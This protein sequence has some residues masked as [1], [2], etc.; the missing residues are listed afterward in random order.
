MAAYLTQVSVLLA[1]D[2]LLELRTRDAFGATLLFALLVLVT[3]NF[4]LD[5]RP[6]VMAGVGPGVLWVA[7]LFAGTIGLGRSF[8]VE[9]DQG[10]LE[11]LL[12]A[13]IERSAL[14]VAKLLGS[15]AVMAVTEAVLVP[16]FAALFDVPFDFRA[17][18]PILF[19]GTVGL[20]TVG[21]LLAA[22]AAHTRAREVLLPVLLFP[23]I[24]PLLIGVVEATGV[25][26]AS[27]T[28]Q[29]RPWIGLLLAFDA[30]Y[31][32]VGNLVFEYVLEE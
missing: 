6:E 11:T 12:A 16:I 23:I 14:F 8:A 24:V 32:A 28:G 13:P 20:A 17:L 7:V 18:L 31:L 15:T 21:T 30:I 29:D 9:R 1:K 26:V 19:L 10:T 25:T 22:I 27:G 5:L 4:A 2:L 3:F